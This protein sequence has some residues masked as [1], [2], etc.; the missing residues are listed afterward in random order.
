VV[1]LRR[2][3]RR[4]HVPDLVPLLVRLALGGRS[5]PTAWAEVELVRRG[6]AAL[7]EQAPLPRQ[8]GHGGAA[9]LAAVERQWA[10]AGVDDDC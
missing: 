9:A 4:V 7:N 10:H 8:G 3:G 2:K 6:E 1:V 5:A